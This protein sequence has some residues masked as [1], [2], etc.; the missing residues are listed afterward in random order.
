MFYQVGQF[1][2]KRQL[3]AFRRV[4]ESPRYAEGGPRPLGA[5]ALS[6][7]SPR[8]YNMQGDTQPV[9]HSQ[10]QHF[11]LSTAVSGHLF[12]SHA[13]LQR[14]AVRQFPMLLVQ[15]HFCTALLRG[16]ASMCSIGSWISCQDK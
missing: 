2:F 14:V 6:L 4:V 7:G 11:F 9:S 15:A 13:S 10:R 16:A 5:L 1:S 8:S 3:A 12:P